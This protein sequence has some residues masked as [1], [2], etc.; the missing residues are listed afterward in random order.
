MN[1]R[2]VIVGAGVSGI[3]AATK[4]IENGFRNILVLDAENRIGGRI[5]TIN[6]ASNVVDLGAQWCHGEKD[7]VVFELVNKYKPFDE[8]NTLWKDSFRRSDGQSSDNHQCEKLISLLYGILANCEEDIKAN[9]YKGS[10]GSYVVEKYRESLRSDEFNDIDAT[11]A[12]QLLEYFHRYENAIESSDT[13]FETSASGYLQYWEC[14]GHPLLNWKDKGYRT[15]IDY[16]TVSNLS[17]LILVS[18]VINCFF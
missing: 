3:A 2:I 12:Q 17:I 5:N 1:S 13:W 6:F 10:L 16:L 8:T 14:D 11:L 15:V 9:N 18:S 4:L 7:N